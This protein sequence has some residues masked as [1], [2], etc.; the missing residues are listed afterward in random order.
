M[1]VRTWSPSA[2]PDREPL[3]MDETRK[4]FTTNGH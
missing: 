1:Q 4:V 2:L 3:I